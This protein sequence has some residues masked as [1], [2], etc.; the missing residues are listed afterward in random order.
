M[1]PKGF[2][3]IMFRVEGGIQICMVQL[4]AELKNG[5]HKFDFDFSAVK[6][7]L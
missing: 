5:Q 1:R 3:D 2:I 7:R 4:E 6:I